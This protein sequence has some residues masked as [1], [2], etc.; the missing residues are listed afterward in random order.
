MIG[1]IDYEAG[2]LASVR[3]ALGHLGHV[4]TICSDPGALHEFDRIILPGVGSFRVAMEALDAKGWSA[5]IR[6]FVA[7]GKP[8]L[9]ICLGM[10]LLFDTGEEHGPRQG[11]G[12]IPGRVT[13]LTPAGRLRVPH[14]GWNNLTTIIPHPL[15]FGIK[16]QVDF[17]FV[18]SFH[19]VPVK[20]SAILATCDYGGEIVS[21]VAMGNVAAVQFH[22]EKSQPS[23]LRLLDNFAD[24]SPE[25]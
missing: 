14:V 5:R 21:A 16:Q 25:C 9:G 20:H 24:W 19:C 17:Y 1:I 6:E 13:A 3:N 10:Q 2:N 22:P 15:L 12:L 23:G 4:A 7:T 18:H 11:L 8:L